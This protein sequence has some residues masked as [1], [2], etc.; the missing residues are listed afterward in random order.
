MGGVDYLGNSNP[1]FLSYWL[2]RNSKPKIFMEALAEYFGNKGN[3]ARIDA[4]NYLK[5]V[6]QQ[7]YDHEAHVDYM[8]KQATE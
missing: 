3:R 5:S 2:S 6:V 4:I 7:Y 8:E 1:H